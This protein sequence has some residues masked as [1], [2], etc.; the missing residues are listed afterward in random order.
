MRTSSIILAAAG[1]TPADPPSTFYMLVWLAMYSIIVW[2]LLS[3]WLADL[4]HDMW[5]GTILLPGVFSDL[6]FLK[7]YCRWGG[8]FMLLLASG[9]CI[10]ALWK[11]FHHGA[12]SI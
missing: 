10:A 5:A 8:V 3:G 7:R 4:A 6:P 12:Q 1:G 9:V 11:H 2:G